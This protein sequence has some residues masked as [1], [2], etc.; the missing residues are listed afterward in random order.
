[1]THK[2]TI[3]L[4]TERLILRRFT[5]DDAEAMFKNWYEDLTIENPFRESNNNVPNCEHL[6]I[7]D[8]RELVEILEGLK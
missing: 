8:W 6:Y 3:T 2:G 7:H 4:K 5:E 1:M